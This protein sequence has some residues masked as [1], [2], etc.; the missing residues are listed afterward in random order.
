MKIA[1]KYVQL[2]WLRIY[3]HVTLKS[4]ILIYLGNMFLLDQKGNGN[5]IMKY[6]FFQFLFCFL[7]VRCVIFETTLIV[8]SE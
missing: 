2:T 7:F 1:K 5:I 4:Q 3:D 8:Y 6:I